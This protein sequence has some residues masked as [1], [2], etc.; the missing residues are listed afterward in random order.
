M[1]DLM[2]YLPLVVGAV[3]TVIALIW[4]HRITDI[5]GGDDPWRFRRR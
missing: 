1:S 3:A 2:P 4:F 5:E